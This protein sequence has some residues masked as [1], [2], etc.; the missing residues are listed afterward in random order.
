MYQVGTE[1]GIPLSHVT[2]PSPRVVATNSIRSR[3]RQGSYANVIPAIV[4]SA[5]P[6]T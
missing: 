6:A 4:T 1:A 5:E 3:F 2:R